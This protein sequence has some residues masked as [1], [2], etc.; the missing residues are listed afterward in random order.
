MRKQTLLLIGLFLASFQCIYAQGSPDY[1]G[2]LKF[3]LNEDGSKYLRLISWAQ[4]Q[5]N[6]NTDDT[7]DANGNENS[8]LNF[9]LRRARVLMFAQINK[10]FLILT[11]F[12]L[13]SLTS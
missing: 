5:A 10:D 11:H 3:K 1:T 2:G 13:N 9:N 12:G 7:F 4:V 8:K 6:Y